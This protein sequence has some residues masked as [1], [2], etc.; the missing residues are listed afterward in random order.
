MD[1]ASHGQR[2]VVSNNSP[3]F[4][5]D[6]HV[7]RLIPGSGNQELVSNHSYDPPGQDQIGLIGEVH[8]PLLQ[9]LSFGAPGAQ[10][11]S[12]AW[13]CEMVMIWLKQS[14]TTHLGMVYSTYLC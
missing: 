10:G 7:F 13:P 2:L 14:G 3:F 1:E 5:W 11:A 9:L 8:V 6:N 12:S 4:Y